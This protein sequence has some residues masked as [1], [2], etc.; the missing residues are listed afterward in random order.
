MENDKVK[1]LM[2]LQHTEWP[3][4][5]EDRPYCGCNNAWE[6]VLLF[7]WSDTIWAHHRFR[8]FPP[9]IARDLMYDEEAI[10]LS[11]QLTPLGC[12]YLCSHKKQSKSKKSS[13]HWNEASMPIQWVCTQVST[14]WQEMIKITQGQNILVQ[15]TPHREVILKAFKT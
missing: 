14:I 13:T 6:R 10:P 9:G 15:N 2:G 7:W 12:G 1:V 3:L 11:P 4:K 5:W 8:H